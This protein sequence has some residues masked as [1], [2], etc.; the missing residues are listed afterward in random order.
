M[1]AKFLKV[2]EEKRVRRLGS[3]RDREVDVQVIAATN[4]DL[5]E[6][7]AGQRFR[8]DLL[9]RL[10]VLSFEIP[11]LRE[12][13][14]DLRALARHYAAT[15]GMRYRQRPVGLAPGAEALLAT[16]PWPGNVRELRNVIERVMLL[17][18][19]D[20]IGAGDFAPLLGLGEPRAPRSFELP[21][22]GLVLEE[23]EKALI[24]QALER[25][26]G[27]RTRAAR[28]LGLSRDTLRY[29]MDKFDLDEFGVA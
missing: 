28:L 25:T 4:Q 20:E 12:R 1:Q 21:E 15:L 14:E 19:G 16:Y 24:R 26:R 2:I 13:P 6:A 27:N 8:A 9:H 3:T 17:A 29:R 18:S 23:L 5:D 10:R 7:V 22:E 11:P